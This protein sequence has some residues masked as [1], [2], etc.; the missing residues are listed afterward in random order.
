M[1]IR[2]SLV[3]GASLLPALFCFALDPGSRA[4]LKKFNASWTVYV[5][6]I[7]TGLRLPFLSYPG[8]HYLAFPWGREVGKH[9]GRVFALNL[10][11][12]PMWDEIVWRGCFLKNIRSV[13][14][15]VS[16]DQSQVGWDHA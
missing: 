12:S 9:L 10:F 5:V 8:T 3:T 1:D 11:L 16:A 6:A 14:A 7:A 15:R 4:S 2:L 13:S